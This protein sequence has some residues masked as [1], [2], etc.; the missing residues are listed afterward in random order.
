MFPS[1]ACGSQSEH[2]CFFLMDR[3]GDC[4]PSHLGQQSG[5]LQSELRRCAAR[6][7]D[8]PAGL[9]ECFQDQGARTTTL[10]LLSR[11]GGSHG[12]NGCSN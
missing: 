4:Q 2:V 8:D 12:K 11:A 1:Y 6:S 10:S 7:P 5:S 3:S 9:L